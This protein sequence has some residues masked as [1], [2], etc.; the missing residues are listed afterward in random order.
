MWI[1]LMWHIRHNKQIM[2]STIKSLLR[3]P[4]SQTVLPKTRT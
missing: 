2:V 4:L 1:R 3:M